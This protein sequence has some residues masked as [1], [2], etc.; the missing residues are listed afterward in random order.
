MS[1]FGNTSH[2]V[3][4]KDHRCQWCGDPILIGERH[5]RYVGKWEGDFQDWRMHTECM[6]GADDQYLADG[7]TP[8]EH[9]RPSAGVTP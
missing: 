4:S 8:Y 7:F 3:A 1:D 6:D 9:D 2:P 5:A